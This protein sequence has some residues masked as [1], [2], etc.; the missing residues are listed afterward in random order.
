M[1][2]SDGLTETVHGTAE[3]SPTNRRRTS[4]LSPWA[5][6]TDRSGSE[7]MRQPPCTC[8]LD[9]LLGRTRLAPAASSTSRANRSA[10]ASR[11]RSTGL[12]AY[13]YRSWLFAATHATPLFSSVTVGSRPLKY[14]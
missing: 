14:P 1:I 3:P 10:V 12:H 6:I 11:S 2:V 13:E 9:W 4:W 7:P 8:V 5:S